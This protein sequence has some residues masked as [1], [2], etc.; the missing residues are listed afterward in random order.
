MA[1]FPSFGA[2]WV[3]SEESFFNDNPIVD[4]LKLRGSYGQNGNLT[5]RYSSLARVSSGEGNQYVFGDGASPSMGQSPASLANTNLTWEKTAGVNIGLDFETMKGRLRGN[6]EYYSTTTTDLLWKMRL[7]QLTGFSEITTNLGRID[8]TGFE[9]SIQMDP[10][11]KQNFSWT[12][13]MNFSSNKNRIVEL[14]GEEDLIASGLF[15]GESIG[16]IYGYEIDGI[17]Q[18]N[19]DIQEGFSPGTYRLVDQNG[20]GAISAEDD[21]IILG[22]TEPAFRAGIL[23]TLRYKDFTFRFF[24]N[25]IQGGKN[26]YLGANHPTGIDATTGNVSNSNWFNS[27]DYWSTVNPDA[28]YPIPWASAQIQPAQYFS[29]NFIRLQDISLSYNLNMAIAENIGIK[30]AKVFLSG[31]NVLTFTKWDGWD[32]ETGQG[33]GTRDAFPVMRAF[34]FGINASF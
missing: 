26:G 11:Q 28:T 17:W 20:D 29:R 21:R 19:D 1:L 15:M 4:F 9:F 2:G 12:L 25:T 23:N 14:L 27:F 5:S 34:T 8:N 24:V 31:K 22:R 30:N 7:P 16:T 3:I 10:V 6:I 13:D 32:P 33:V 18:V